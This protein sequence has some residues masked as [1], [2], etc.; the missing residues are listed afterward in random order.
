ML[1]YPNFFKN[2]AIFRIIKMI[3]E[4]VVKKVGL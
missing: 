3:C 1:R 2:D 4:F